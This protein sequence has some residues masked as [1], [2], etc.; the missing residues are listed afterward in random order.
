MPFEKESFVSIYTSP[1]FVCTSKGSK[2]QRISIFAQPLYSELSQFSK[3]RNGTN[4][5]RKRIVCTSP[6]AGPIS[7]SLKMT[8]FPFW[9]IF[10]ILKSLISFEAQTKVGEVQTNTNDSLS[11]G[12][13]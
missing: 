8:D 10:E 13:K 2:I 11:N 4:D 3:Y 12:I 1:T 6:F 7:I 9:R 5:I